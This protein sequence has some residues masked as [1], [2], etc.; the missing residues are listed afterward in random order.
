MN[1]PAPA[2]PA[3]PPSPEL[4]FSSEPAPASSAPT[5]AAVDPMLEERNADS[6]LF[7]L[8]QIAPRP[9]NSTPLDRLATP[10]AGGASGGQGGSGLIDIKSLMTQTGPAADQAVAEAA[11][12]SSHLESNT[13]MAAAR[14]SLIG[15]VQAQSATDHSIVAAAVPPAAKRGPLIVLCLLAAGALAAAI[16]A[17]VIRG[18]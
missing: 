9:G 2:A 4:L 15:D 1:L 3:A 7:K 13:S 12:L 10:A 18:V 8:D 17:V 14:S 6:V 11:P 5:A 16:A